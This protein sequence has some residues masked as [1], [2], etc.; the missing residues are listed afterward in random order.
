MRIARASGWIVALAAAG[1]LHAAPVSASGGDAA[2]GEA[3][4][5]E[6]CA[7]CHANAGRIAT[8]AGRMEDAALD[9]FLAGHYAADDATRADVIAFLDGI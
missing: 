4:F 2:R 3:A 8:R 1:A 9:A 7:G 6:S 5:A